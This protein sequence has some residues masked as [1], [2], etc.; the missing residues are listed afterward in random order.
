[1]IRFEVLNIL[2][3]HMAGLSA[4]AWLELDVKSFR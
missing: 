4:E 1:M 2:G 3:L